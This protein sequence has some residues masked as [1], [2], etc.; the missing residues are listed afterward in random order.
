MRLLD[1]CLID[2]HARAGEPPLRL[3]VPLLDDYLRF[4]AGRC[5]PNT[6][7]AAAYDLKVFF[8]VVDKQPA[9]VQP[10]DVLAFVTA[11]RTGQPSIDGVLKPVVVDDEAGVSLRTVRRRLSIVSGLY[12]FL[13]ARGDVSAQPGA[14]R[15][16]DPAGTAASASGG[17]VGPRD[18]HA[19]AHPD[20]NRGGR[21]DRGAAHASGSGDGGGD[22]AR[23]AAPRRGPRD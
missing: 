19:A 18:T 13:H 14:A 5:R 1:L 8:T 17:A 6:V 12:A 9:D 16:A 21:V 7:L 15:V 22:G 4:L 10:G 20:P 23:W 3:G 2:V 11:Q